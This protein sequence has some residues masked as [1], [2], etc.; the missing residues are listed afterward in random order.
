MPAESHA[1]LHPVMRRACHEVRFRMRVRN[2]MRTGRMRRGCN[3]T[4]QAKAPPSRGQRGLEALTKQPHRLIE[5]SL[6]GFGAAKWHA[7]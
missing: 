7:Q 4:A 5:D 2:R 1:E 3:R 6:M